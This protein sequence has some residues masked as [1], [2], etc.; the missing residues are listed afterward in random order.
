ML[1]RMGRGMTHKNIYI[2]TD[3][4]AHFLCLSFYK[5]RRFSYT[6]IVITCERIKNHKH[7]RNYKHVA[8]QLGNSNPCLTL[9]LIC[10]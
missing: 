6:H 7:E 9:F 10:S 5:L 1:E 4:I 8:N 3:S 2:N